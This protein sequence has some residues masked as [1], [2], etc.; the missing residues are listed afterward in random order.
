[1]SYLII[2]C[3][4]ACLKLGFAST[5]LICICNLIISISCTSLCSLKPAFYSSV[6]I[7]A[8]KFFFLCCSKLTY[9]SYCLCS[10]SSYLFFS[11]RAFSL[12]LFSSASFYSAI[13]LSASTNSF[14]P[15]VNSAVLASFYTCSCCCYIFS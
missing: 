8:S 7:L 13:A 9:S 6:A 12:F 3:S 2:G 10:K 11:L 15:G 1:M 14:S 4:F 5:P